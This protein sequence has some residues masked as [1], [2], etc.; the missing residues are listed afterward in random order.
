M[1][2][3]LAFGRTNNAAPSMRSLGDILISAMVIAICFWMLAALSFVAALCWLLDVAKR[4][5]RNIF[6]RHKEGL[7]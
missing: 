2:F 3:R 4:G 1:S 6:N 5:L 7:K